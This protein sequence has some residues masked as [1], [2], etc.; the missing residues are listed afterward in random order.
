MNEAALFGEKTVTTK[1]LADILTVAKDT[2]NATVERLELNGV[3][4]RVDIMRKS[5]GGYL[6]D[7]KQATLIKQEI[8]KHHNLA[9]RQIDGVSTDYEMELMTQKVLAYH[10]QKAN[11]YKERA[12]LA[13]QKLIEQAPKVDFYDTVTQST[14]AIDMKEVAKTL[15]I[16]G[17]GR[18]KL[19]ALLRD[20]GV[21]DKKNLPYQEYV[22]RGYFKIVESSFITKDGGKGVSLKTVVFQ[23]GLDFIRKTLEKED[24]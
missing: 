13:E 15:N 24:K 23:K 22:N 2:V 3:L 12:E 21:L 7:E 19:F 10:I 1:E 4:R 11:E 16:D 5:Q 8:Q 14:D 20:R 6:F 9:S 18:N 17:L